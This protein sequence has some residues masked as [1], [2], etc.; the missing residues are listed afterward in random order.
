MV[1]V[2]SKTPKQPKCLQTRQ[3]P[4]EHIGQKLLQ[5]S[6]KKANWKATKEYLN[7]RGTKIR[8]FRVLFRPLSSHSLISPP[9][10]PSGP[11]HSPTTS[12]L[13]TSPFIPLFL[14]PRQA[15]YKSNPGTLIGM[16]M[17]K[18]TFARTIPDDLRAPHVKMWGFEAKRAR[19]FTRTS[20]RTL[21]CFFH[22]HLPW[23]RTGKIQ[24]NKYLHC[25]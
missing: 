12:P 14:T 5:N 16:A 7:D 17:F 13:F 2:G 11:L 9:L 15:A 23:F 10:S 20:P 19:K 8:V 6:R 4:I 18:R 21:P 25:Q 24:H 3:N 22:Y 1:N